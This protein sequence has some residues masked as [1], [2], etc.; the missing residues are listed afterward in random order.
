MSQK[1]V[2]I[3]EDALELAYE[4][5]KRVWISREIKGIIRRITGRG[6]RRSPEE[7]Q[8]MKVG[9]V[10]SYRP[11]SLSRSVDV[12][13]KNK[14]LVAGSSV[15]EIAEEVAKSGIEAQLA[16]MSDPE[17]KKEFGSLKDLKGYLKQRGVEVH[18]KATWKNTLVILRRS[19]LWGPLDEEE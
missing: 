13:K 2:D 9:K 8:E 5:Q 1:L 11:G 4:D 12:K 7:V 19:L 14:A 18:P 6:I 15:K 3:L 17:L 16:Q 10:G